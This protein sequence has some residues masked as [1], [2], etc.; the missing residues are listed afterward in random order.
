MGATV[1][2][3]YG[4]FIARYPEFSQVDAATLQEYF[5]DATL[6]VDN[7]GASRV[8]SPQALSSLLNMVT[9]HLAYLFAP[10]FNG[11]ST[12]TNPAAIPAP[13]VV[14]R[15]SSASEGSVSVTTEYALGNPS[16]LA[17]FF[18]QTKYGAM[19]WAA[20]APYRT[21]AY[22]PG[23]TRSFTPYFPG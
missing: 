8:K 15:I 10:Q 22:V 17:A 21:F 14:G 16:A 20:S 7:T 13:N 5:N 6:F 9:A 4:S 23:Y 19:Y 1:N 11:Q 3:S 2:F 12:T 18:A